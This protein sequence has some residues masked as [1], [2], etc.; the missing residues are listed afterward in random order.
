MCF[1][2]LIQN[3]DG[4]EKVKFE[5]VILEIF[6]H[7]HHHRCMTFKQLSP[8][9]YSLLQWKGLAHTLRA[10]LGVWHSGSALISASPF[11]SGHRHSRQKS[12]CGMAPHAPPTVAPWARTTQHGASPSAP[13]ARASR[14]AVSRR[15]SRAATSRGAACVEVLASRLMRQLRLVRN[16]EDRGQQHDG[17]AVGRFRRRRPRR[18]RHAWAAAHRSR[19]NAHRTMADVV[20]AAPQLL[21]RV[22]CHWCWNITTHM[23]TQTHNTTHTVGERATNTDRP[24]N[25]TDAFVDVNSVG[26]LGDGTRWKGC[27]KWEGRKSAPSRQSVVPAIWEASAGLC[28]IFGYG[29]RY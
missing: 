26:S 4:M 20:A 9:M 17:A 16:I 6:T 15:R 22:G 10:S 3:K 2:L 19:A 18:L 28:G 23:R 12:T 5:T 8:G 25:D 24:P 29:L 14:W 21:S 1:L 7:L 13:A 27:R 11:R